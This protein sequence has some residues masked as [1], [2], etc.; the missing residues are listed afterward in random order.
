MGPPFSSCRPL[1]AGAARPASA[2]GSYP[3]LWGRKGGCAVFGLI[4][5]LFCGLALALMGD[6]LFFGGNLFLS[7]PLLTAPAAGLCGFLVALVWYF[8]IKSRERA[9]KK[10]TK[11][12]V[13]MAA[14]LLCCIGCLVYLLVRM[15]V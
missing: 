11:A 3:G 2:T 6:A 4:A 10:R 8:D 7:L 1:E 5:Y 12:L 14:A 9:K 15:F 13:A